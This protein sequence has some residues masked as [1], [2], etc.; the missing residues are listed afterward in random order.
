MSIA[1]DLRA[2]PPAERSG[3]AFGKI[4]SGTDARQFY[5]QFRSDFR[6]HSP[7]RRICITSPT[8]SES[9]CVFGMQGSILDIISGLGMFAFLLVWL[10]PAMFGSIAGGG[11][12]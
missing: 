7:E 12:P 5:R 4:E 8:V 2:F 6:R 10:D 9:N 11:T 1:V 3:H